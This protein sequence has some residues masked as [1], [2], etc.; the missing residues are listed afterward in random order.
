M[1]Q[2]IIRRGNFIMA[3]LMVRRSDKILLSVDGRRGT[4]WRAGGHEAS[5]LGNFTVQASCDMWFHWCAL[6]DAS[7]ITIFYFMTV[8]ATIMF[9]FVLY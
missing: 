8:R 4:L 9:L 7:S 6:K 2:C 1:P 3:G 5:I